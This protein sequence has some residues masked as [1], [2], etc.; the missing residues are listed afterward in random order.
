M[1]ETERAESHK[2][3]VKGFVRENNRDGDLH[4]NGDSEAKNT[5]ARQILP[6]EFPIVTM[7]LST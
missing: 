1:R 6:E 3:T 7:E 2:N 4:E 5:N